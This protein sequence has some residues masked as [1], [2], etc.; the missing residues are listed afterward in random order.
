[1]KINKRLIFEMKECDVKEKEEKFVKNMYERMDD[2]AIE[3]IILK[4]HDQNI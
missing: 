3:S 1:M 2:C 4:C